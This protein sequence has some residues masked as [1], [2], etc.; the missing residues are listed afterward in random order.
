MDFFRNVIYCM[1]V[2]LLRVVFVIVLLGLVVIPLY[3]VFFAGI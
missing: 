1:V 2:L 3:L